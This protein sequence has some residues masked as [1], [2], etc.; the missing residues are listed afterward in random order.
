[1]PKLRCGELCPARS[2]MALS[3]YM[4]RYGY[5]LERTIGVIHVIALYEKALSLF[6]Q[7]I[8]VSGKRFC[9]VGPYKVVVNLRAFCI[10]E[11]LY[12]IV[13]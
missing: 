10:R 12:L 1:M 11:K 9:H 3:S 4:Q 5:L 8:Q 2:R 7:E 6:L 13:E